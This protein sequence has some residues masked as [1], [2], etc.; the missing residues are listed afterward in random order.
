MQDTYGYTFRY[1]FLLVSA[2][3]VLNKA[4]G[5]TMIKYSRKRYQEALRACKEIA[6]NSRLPASQRLRAAELI[7]L[8]YGGELLPGGNSKRDKRTIKDLVQ[9]RSVEKQIRSVVNEQTKPQTEEQAEE[10]K[11]SKALAEFLK[12]KPTQTESVVN[13]KPHAETAPTVPPTPKEERERRRWLHRL[14]VA[15][16]LAQS[17]KNRIAAIRSIQGRLPEVNPLRYRNAE[18][19]LQEIK[20][21]WHTRP[22]WDG[23]R[24]IERSVCRPARELSDLWG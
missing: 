8:L 15:G 4:E 16:D 6:K 17:K 11:V 21:S 7:Y 5:K 12:V 3:H 18:K 10:D 9:E 1:I 23:H 2:P 19:L 14:D 13:S 20:E 24:F 22:F